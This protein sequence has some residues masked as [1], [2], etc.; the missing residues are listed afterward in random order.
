MKKKDS[1][2][3]ALSTSCPCLPFT[4]I[5]WLKGPYKLLIPKL[6]E[7]FTSPIY[8]T[9]LTS[10]LV[11]EIPVCEER[12]CHIH[13]TPNESPPGHHKFPS[14]HGI[15]AQRRKVMHSKDQPRSWTQADHTFLSP[16]FS[17]QG[18][19]PQIS[20]KA[21]ELSNSWAVPHITLCNKWCLSCIT[22]MLVVAFLYIKPAD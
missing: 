20:Q 1:A 11:I 4:G 14:K 7:S 3:V 22:P 13:I 19:V 8:K 15:I 2:S 5:H 9:S 12:N 10:D 21:W 16:N 6:K 17:L 18:P